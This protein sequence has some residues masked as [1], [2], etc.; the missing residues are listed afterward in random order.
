MKRNPGHSQKRRVK[1]R[2]A[3]RHVQTRDLTIEIASRYA[4]AERLVGARSRPPFFGCVHRRVGA[5]YYESQDRHRLGNYRERV[6]WSGRAIV[7]GKKCFIARNRTTEEPDSHMWARS[8]N[9]RHTE[10]GVTRRR[11]RRNSEA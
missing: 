1:T 7:E 5:L 8:G 4:V 2:Y 11:K 6:D 9:R 3:G 10:S